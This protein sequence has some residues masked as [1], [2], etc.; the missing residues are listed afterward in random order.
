MANKTIKI[1]IVNKHD[2]QSNWQKAINFTPKAGELI[3]YDD[4]EKI[5]I[6][7]GKSNV[8]D[9][10]FFQGS[11]E[12]AIDELSSNITSLSNF[13]Y[14]NHSNP[15]YSAVLNGVDL[16]DYNTPAACGFYYAEGN[17]NCLNCP[18]GINQGFALLVGR[19]ASSYFYQFYVQA[20]TGSANCTMFTRMFGGGV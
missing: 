18:S 5:K 19:A 6:G 7:D 15:I 16:N 4:L 14:S 20:D 3:I 11:L 10:P 12:T 17:H 9:L 13:S 2:T 1:R 8:N